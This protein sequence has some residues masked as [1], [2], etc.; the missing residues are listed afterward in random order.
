MKLFKTIAVITL[1]TL[2]IFTTFTIL[3]YYITPTIKPEIKTIK[4]YNQG[5][6]IQKEKLLMMKIN[7]L[8]CK[9]T[10]IIDKHFN[11]LSLLGVYIFSQ[12]LNENW[13]LNDVKQLVYCK[14][15]FLPFVSNDYVEIDV[16]VLCKK[17]SKDN[18]DKNTDFEVEY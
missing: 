9:E 16:S 3:R 7:S 1:S 14:E 5:Y 12:G 8:N 11:A 18:C 10:I 15:R 4:F 13:I 6:N 2:A 17:Y